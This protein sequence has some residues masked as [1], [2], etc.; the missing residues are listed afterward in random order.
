MCDPISLLTVGSAVLSAGG[1]IFSGMQQSGAYNDQAAFAERTAVR[2]GTAGWYEASRMREASQRQ[3]GD[4]QQQFISG[5]IKLEGSA[6]AVLADMETAAAL[7]EQAILYDTRQKQD[8]L[9][10]E[11]KLAKSNASSAMIGGF[12]GGA[13][14]LIGGATGVAKQRSTVTMLSN[15]YAVA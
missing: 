13:S 1:S 9:R 6:D 3:V 11:S 15:P 5:G 7:D 8:N 10:F 12:L 2:E 14:A 4:V